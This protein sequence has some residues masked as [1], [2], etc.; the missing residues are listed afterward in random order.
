MEKYRM[1][2]TLRTIVFSYVKILLLPLLFGIFLYIFAMVIVRAEVDNAH[3]QL[4]G[5]MGDSIRDNIENMNNVMDS[6]LADDTVKALAKKNRY[7]KTDYL[8]MRE[9][10]DNLNLSVIANSYMDDIVL[11]FHQ[12][13]TALSTQYY[14]SQVGQI[15]GRLDILA[16]DVDA[17]YREL[18]QENNLR[19]FITSVSIPK[20]PFVIRSNAS[21]ALDGESTVT[22]FVRLRRDT[23]NKL[24]REENSETFLFDKN[25]EYLCT[26]QA[27]SIAPAS[28][29]W[30][31]A[32]A[33]KNYRNY[34][35]L[36][37]PSLLQ[38]RF[39]RLIPQE[40]YSRNIFY[41]KLLLLFYVLICLAVGIP[42]AGSMVHR[43]YNPI[44]QIVSILPE[45]S[46]QQDAD[47]FRL[48]EQS[49]TELVQR[50]LHNEEII[51]RR[52]NAMKNYLMYRVIQG[53]AGFQQQFLEEMKSFGIHFAHEGFLMA[54][55]DIEDGSNLFF[56]N[57]EQVNQEMSQLAFF[58][59]T[60]LLNER[61]GRDYPFFLAE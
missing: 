4:I 2:Q 36:D 10:Q 40:V 5:H 46:S 61:L 34:R 33:G 41:M 60:K 25:G 26:G 42:L 6:L 53:G 57:L 58:A 30:E 23:L 16:M 24:M 43:S 51:D 22:I 52:T 27:E 28:E 56:E 17:F 12:T 8:K 50:N 37:G 1:N 21:L 13:D 54:G 14:F 59:V 18:E 38:M 35:L 32:G 31:A 29:V 48:I 9:I 44:K 11:Y 47:D 7:T 19:F 15:K 45:V 39:V 3:M 49:L 20:M 55:I